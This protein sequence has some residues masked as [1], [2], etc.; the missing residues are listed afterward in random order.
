MTLD[1]GHNIY[2][3]VLVNAVYNFAVDKFFIW[4]YLESQIF[5]PK[6]SD[7]DN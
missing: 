4:K 7:F 3:K 6:F 5:V 1:I 2:T